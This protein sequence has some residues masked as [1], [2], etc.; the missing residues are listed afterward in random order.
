MLTTFWVV[1]VTST[2]FIFWTY[3]G[4]AIVTLFLRRLFKRKHHVDTSYTP[5]VTILIPT[6][7]EKETILGKLNNTLSLSYPRKLVEIIV[8]DDAS[9]DETVRLVAPYKAQGVKVIEKKLRG[10]KAESVN[11]GAQNSTSEIIVVT[12]ADVMLHKDSLPLLLQHFCDLK[13]GAVSGA[14]QPVSI[15]ENGISNSTST[16]WKYE[17][18]VLF[19]ESLIDSQT[20]LLGSLFAVSRK[21]LLDHSIDQSNVAEDFDFAIRIRQH[22]LRVIMEPRATFASIVPETSTNVVIQRTRTAIGTI[23]TLVKHRRML[24]NFRYGYFGLVE[25]P[26]HKLGQMFSPLYF[27]IFFVSLAL[28]TLYDIVAVVTFIV[29]GVGISYIA[30]SVSVR[31]L[32]PKYLVQVYKYIL[33]LQWIV[34]VAWWKYL[35][36]DISV[37]WQQIRT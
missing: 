19:N 28:L 1:L 26:S 31:S 37:T 29:F 5:T 34:L 17:T 13:I 21:I 18:Q 11:I 20:Y 3:L 27:I 36:R 10:G 4:Y 15:L 22:G 23:Q 6:H 35:R 14:L 9:S 32:H 30:I 8:I 25:L 2:I 33:L 12:D 7:N 24:W 16:F